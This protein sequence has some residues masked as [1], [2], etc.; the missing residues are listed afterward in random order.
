MTSTRERSPGVAAGPGT[1]ADDELVRSGRDAV[2]TRR[3][4]VRAARRRFA[5][6]GYRA[7]TVRE[8]AADVGVNVALINRYF[9]S[10]EGLFEECMARTS[11]ELD[12]QNPAPSRGLDEVVER[13]IAHVVNAPDGDDPLQLLLLLRSSGD[14]NADRIRS[15]TLEHFTRR[16]ATAAGWTADAPDAVGLLLRAQLAI[17]TMLGVLMLRTSAAV[18]PLASAGS[19]DLSGPL[20][21]VFRDLLSPEP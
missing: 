9:V 19:D 6:Q 4:L 16:L 1:S 10:K 20:G 2:A 7:T 15:R 3:A 5:T 21:Q 11:D 18:Q 13:L 17:A 14:V 12:E 8:I